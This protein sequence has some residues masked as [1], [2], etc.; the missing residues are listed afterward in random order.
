MSCVTLTFR[1]WIQVTVTAHRLNEDNICTKLDGNRCVRKLQSGHEML[2]TDGQTDRRTKCIPII[3]SPLRG[4][5][6]QRWLDVTNQEIVKFN[7][8]M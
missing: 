1:V 8:V 7:V 3:P 4:G 5:E 2:Q 6:L